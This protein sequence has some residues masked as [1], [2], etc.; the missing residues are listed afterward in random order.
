MTAIVGKTNYTTDSNNFTLTNGS[1][2]GRAV[3]VVA[4]QMRLPADMSTA[5]FNGIE[6]TADLGVHSGN[7][8]RGIRTSNDADITGFAAGYLL[9]YANSAYTE[10]T[11]FLI[12]NFEIA[13]L[14]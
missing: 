5:T 14:T 4:S 3:V 8:N 11:D 10:D 2:P 1:A 9:G 12:D 13:S 6:G 7:G